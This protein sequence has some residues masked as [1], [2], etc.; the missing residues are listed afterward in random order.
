MKNE[1]LSHFTTECPW[2]DTL[3]WYDTVDSTNT[4]AK[5]LA[6]EG[7]S[8]G[9]VLIAG[10]QTGGRGRLGRSFSSP[11]GMGLYLSVILRPKCTPDKLMHL[12]CAAAVAACKAVETAAGIIPN[13]KWTNDLVCGTKKLGGI[14]TELSLDSKTSLVEYAIVGIGINCQQQPEDFPLE[15]QNMAT[16]I[17]QL[18]N[19]DFS[20]QKLAA[21]LIQSL[22]QMDVMLLT[23]KESIM[24]HYRSRCMTLGQEISVVQGDHVRYATALSVDN[25]GGLTVRYADGQL[26]TVCS[27][28]VSIRG[29]YGYV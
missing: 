20:P 7:A 22:F 11:D 28:E 3:Y 8:H 17:R 10:K 9:T 15:L 14:L 4:R 27:G 5:H 1:I 29:M 26:Q 21:H 18:T 19:T 25:D 12:T 6:K 23:Q 24:D 16:S 2:R 13:I